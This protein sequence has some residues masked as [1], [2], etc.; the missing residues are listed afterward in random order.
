[1]VVDSS[2]RGKPESC[3][4]IVMQYNTLY[5]QNTFYKEFPKVKTVSGRDIIFK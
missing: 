3:N 4:L 1:M 2:R 5:T